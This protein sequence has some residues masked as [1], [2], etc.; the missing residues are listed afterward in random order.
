[1]RLCYYKGQV[2]NFGDD[3][4]PYILK[5]LFP[6]FE[7]VG[8]DDFIFLIGTILYN[9]YFQKNKIP[10]S[11]VDGRR[12]FVLGSGI[13]FINNP[14][15]IDDDWDVVFLR[16]PLSAALLNMDISKSITDPAYLIRKMSVFNR[17]NKIPKEYKISII[18]HFLSINRLN[19]DVIC[20]KFNI[21]LIDFSNPDLDF[22]LEELA[23]SEFILTEAMHGAIL[24]DALR[25][26]WNR[27]N[28]FSRVHESS[29]V[30]EFKWADWMLSVN[31]S[32]FP[33][34]DFSNNLILNEMDKR[35]SFDFYR[36]LRT[37]QFSEKLDSFIL[38][39]DYRI[40]DNSVLVDRVEMLDEAISDFKSKFLI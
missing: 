2:A 19:W 6:D 18:P 39:R 11:E 21:N 9:N 5:E 15:K 14:L 20:K 27:F 4:N 32:P 34:F 28:F 23:K 3:L 7:R 35:F 36:V 16:G 12:K 29:L 1:M 26:P 10:K 13:R 25:I 17:L 30:S 24:A 33:A 37:K 40:S 31:V 8:S 22:V 38:Q